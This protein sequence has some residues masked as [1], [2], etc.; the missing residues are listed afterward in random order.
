[1]KRICHG[2]VLPRLR[3][4]T[5][6]ALL[7][8]IAIRGVIKSNRRLGFVMDEKMS[9]KILRARKV[10][11]QE[12]FLEKLN[13]IYD[14]RTSLEHEHRFDHLPTPDEISHCI[15]NPCGWTTG[16]EDAM[17]NGGVALDMYL[18]LGDAAWARKI[19]RGL[20]R[21]GTVSG[22]PG[23]VARSVSPRDGVSFYP[24]SSRDQYTHYVYG[25][26]SYFRSPFATAE[27]KLEITGLLVDVARFC[28]TY[29]TEEND[30]TLPRADFGSPRS[31]V[32]KLWHVN[33]HEAARLPMFY[34]AAYAVSD[35]IHWL[36]CCRKYA[37]PAAAESMNLRPKSYHS[38]ALMQML[39]SCRLLHEVLPEPAL[40]AQYSEVMKRIDPY[41]DFNV[42]R[43][44]TDSYL[45]DFQAKMTD[46]RDIFN[47][48]VMH[49]CRHVIPCYPEDYS[50][51]AR[52]V[53]ETGEAVLCSLLQLKPEVNSLRR[54]VYRF[55]LDKFEPE[56]YMPYGGLYL[57]A[58]WYKAKKLGIDLA[59]C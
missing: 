52:T 28:E 10:F 41:F 44:G 58:A 49:G 37:G 23:F 14:Y 53:R 54:R 18:D 7:V 48:T 9:E 29:V 5:M 26:W 12:Y 1:M 3:I 47:C 51:A 45:V 39:C 19:Y 20:K 24:E 42:C 57:I 33:P 31:S 38:F 56:T 25:L 15:P 50:L 22:V 27:E 17:I 11:E 35:D 43:A 8:V 34:A 21:C 46:W 16:M 13:L 59:A 4:F 2:E 30:W 55:V 6:I 32:C 40:K 36:D